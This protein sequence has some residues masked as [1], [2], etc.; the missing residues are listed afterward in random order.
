MGIVIPGTM[1]GQLANYDH[2]MFDIGF[3]ASPHWSQ[4][5][6]DDNGKVFEVINPNNNLRIN[7]SYVP[8]CRNVQKHMK[9][10]AGLKGMITP[11]K[12]HDT[13]L[14]DKQALILQGMCIEGKEPYRRMVVGIP[15]HDGLYIME[16]CCPEA[17]YA[18]HRERMQDILG[19]LHVGA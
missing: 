6:H 18:G 3:E 11:E 12:A 14:N 13:V 7:L 19:T 17:C 10:L 2:P 5:L 15:G 4:T 16:I 1:N 8:G 9:H